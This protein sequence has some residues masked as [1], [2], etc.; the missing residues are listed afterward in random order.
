MSPRFA[1]LSLVLFGAIASPSARAAE[2]CVATDAQLAS[3]AIQAQDDL[4]E[5]TTIKLVQGVYHIAG[6]RF[7]G[8]NYIKT[9][10]LGFSLLGGYTANCASRQVDPAN[11]EIVIGSLASFDVHMVFGLTIE[12]IHFSGANAGMNIIWDDSNGPPPDVNLV[13]R[14]NIVSGST[15]SVPILIQWLTQYSTGSLN[16]RLVDNLIHDNPGPDPSHQGYCVIELRDPFA[17]SSATFDLINNTVVDNAVGDGGVCF[18]R[19]GED[20]GFLA[21]YNNIL[22]GNT[23]HDLASGSIALALADNVIGTSSYPGAI[24][25]TGTLSG[26]PKLDVNFRPVESPLSPVINSGDDSVPGGLPAHDLDGG[27]RVVGSAVDRGA[28]ESSINNSFIQDVTNTN[29]S[30]AGSLRAAINSVNA[31][32]AGLIRFDIGTGC[33]PHVIT[34]DSPLPLIAASPVVIDGYYQ[35]GSAQNDLDVGDDA[36]ICVILESGNSSASY[37][38]GVDSSSTATQLTVEGLAFSGFSAAAIDLQGGSFHTIAGNHFGGNVGG[39]ALFANGVDIYL[40]TVTHDVTIGGDDRASRNI[41]GD[42]IGDG[43]ELDGGVAG[44]LLFGTY[45]DQVLNNYI[46]VGWNKAG[47]SYTNRA[48]GTR[49]IHVLGH[50]DT[51]RGNLIGHNVTDGIDLDGDGAVGNLIAANLIGANAAGT[52]LGNASMGVRTEND[53]HDNTIRANTIAHNGQKGVR[54]V[55]GRGNKIRKNSIYGNALLGIDL[56]AEGVT[57]NDDDGALEPA[58]YANRGQNFPVLTAAIGGTSSG[59]LSGVLTTTPGDYTVD[60]YLG[61]GCD[62]SGYGEGRAWLRGATVTV[63]QPA[64]GD[65]GTAAF[66]IALKPAPPTFL[67]VGEAI[68]ATATDAAGDTSE[69][70]ACI[71]YVDDTIYADGFDPP[72]I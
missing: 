59:V 36:T 5:A 11:T 12:G 42:A 2:V 3:A 35:T 37:A 18:A 28:Y 71:D 33:G 53:A 15:D 23:G 29:D 27:P 4:T 6:T 54:I 8:S 34:L 13:L 51:I 22:Y 39:H 46:G 14:R 24:L 16:A 9:F 30:D 7:D 26:D 40:G 56:A 52:N 32:G 68:T 17:G 21:A 55:T 66:T 62:P 50:D 25:Q 69:F 48:N 45:N 20:E 61:S 57:A 41:V 63:P 70:S 44:Q 65:Q 10:A 72:L 43:I 19:Q 49:G 1:V 47:A 64:I 58:T 38:F 60:V 67:L 31:N